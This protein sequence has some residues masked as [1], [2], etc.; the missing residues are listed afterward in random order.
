MTNLNLELIISVII[1]LISV[2]IF[3]GVY[4]TTVDFIQQQVREIK[5]NLKDDKQELKD[6]MRKYNSVLERM[7]IVEQST[8]SAHKRIDN[9]ENK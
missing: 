3:I 2:G 7:I 4:R 1:Q 9:M 5:Q 6:D 8:K